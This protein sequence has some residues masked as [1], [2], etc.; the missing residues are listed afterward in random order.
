[1]QRG[2]VHRLYQVV[3]D[4]QDSVGFHI[5]FTPKPQVQPSLHQFSRNSHTLCHIICRYHDTEFHDK[6]DNK[7]IKY[8]IQIHLFPLVKYGFH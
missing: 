4:T 2:G 6:S 3:L 8:T 1:M 5:R 7:F